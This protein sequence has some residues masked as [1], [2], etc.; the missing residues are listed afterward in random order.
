MTVVLIVLGIPLNLML[1]RFC[2]LLFILAFNCTI[3]LCHNFFGPEWI[4]K[5]V[6]WIGSHAVP[7]VRIMVQHYYI[8]SG[9]IVILFTYSSVMPIVHWFRRRTEKQKIED[10]FNGIADLC[11]RMNNIETRQ[12]E[13]L[14]ILRD[15]NDKCKR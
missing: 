2:R 4:F 10:M 7:L 5:K 3:L 9:A 12:E 6:Y 13:M 1:I 8:T 15:L 11:E 14:R